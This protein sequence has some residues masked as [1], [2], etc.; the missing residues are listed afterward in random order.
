[1]S[2]GLAIQVLGHG[3]LLL[4]Q[5]WPSSIF[6]KKKESQK[7]NRWGAMT[8]NQSS[9]FWIFFC[10]FFGALEKIS[11]NQSIPSKVSTPIPSVSFHHETAP[12]DH[13]SRV[14]LLETPGGRFHWGFQGLALGYMI[15][16]SQTPA[17]SP[18]CFQK[19]NLTSIFWP[20]GGG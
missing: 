11:S 20:F 15:T 18:G 12:R 1:M 10:F 9:Y 16:W 6:N 17:C 7:K 5:V 3:F 2:G 19:G 13:D 4:A 8:H 14:V